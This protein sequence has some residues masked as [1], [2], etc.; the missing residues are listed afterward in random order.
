V[1]LALSG[2]SLPMAEQAVADLTQRLRLT[3]QALRLNRQRAGGMA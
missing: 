3:Q 1:G 2:E